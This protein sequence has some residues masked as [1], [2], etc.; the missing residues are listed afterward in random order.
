MNDL[1]LHLGEWPWIFVMALAV[2]LSFEHWNFPDLTIESTFTA[3]MTTVYFVSKMDVPVASRVLLVIALGFAI[4][5][6]LSL[7]TWALAMLRFPALFAGLVVMLSAYSLNY[8]LNGGALSQ[9]LQIRTDDLPS[10]LRFSGLN[11]SEH[12][13]LLSVVSGILVAI[14]IW[15]FDRS[16]RGR[17][18]W[19]SRRTIESDVP[20]ALG[21]NAPSRLYISMVVYN[22]VAF[23][24]G[25][26]FALQNAYSGVSFV[27]AIAPGIACM[28]ILR[29]AKNYA[30]SPSRRCEP[31]RG[32]T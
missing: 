22:L 3:G 28:F 2:Y 17:R 20:H 30:A 9:Q 11:A 10:W 19:I 13:F 31:R 15:M 14:M 16:I 4:C 23:V 5:L 21:I 7:A 18:L 8:H 25:L 26:G 24:G 6:V 1:I 27:G 12:Y 29:A 32:A